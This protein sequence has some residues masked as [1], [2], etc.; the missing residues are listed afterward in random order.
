MVFFDNQIFTISSTGIINVYRLNSDL[1]NGIALMTSVKGVDWDNLY[2]IRMDKWKLAEEEEKHRLEVIDKIN[3]KI[4]ERE[5][6]RNQTNS[7][8]SNAIVDGNSTISKN[9]TKNESN[10]NLLGGKNPPVLDQQ[11]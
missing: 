3:E 2:Q 6:K 9:D 10:S 5:N 8:D 11:P 4:A 1:E 7:T